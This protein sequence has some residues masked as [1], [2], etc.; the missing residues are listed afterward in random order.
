MH[1]KKT[2]TLD[3]IKIA[4]WKEFHE[5][6]ELWFPYFHDYPNENIENEEVTNSFWAEFLEELDKTN[7]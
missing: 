7:K 5:S 2:Y 4:F 3:Q 1:T 6:G